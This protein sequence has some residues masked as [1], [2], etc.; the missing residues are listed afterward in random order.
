[1]IRL[2]I[3]ALAAIAAL[4]AFAPKTSQGFGAPEVKACCELAT[5]QEAG[6]RSPGM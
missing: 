2:I 5:P 3:I 4:V 1:M 6:N